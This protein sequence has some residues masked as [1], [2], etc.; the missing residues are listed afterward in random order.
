MAEETKSVK[1][2]VEHFEFAPLD[3]K[4][5]GKEKP[6]RILGLR[7]VTMNVTVNQENFYADNS[8]FAILDGGI[9][10][11]GLDLE[12]A[13]ISS[14]NK[15]ALLGVELENGME[16]YKKNIQLPYVACTFK[17]STNTG[18]AVWFGFVKGKFSLPSTDLST[19]EGSPNPN[20]DT[21]S[22]K[23]WSRGSDELMYVIAREDSADFDLE[24]F[25]NK[26]YGSA[27]PG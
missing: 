24:Q 16:L 15:Q 21:L 13:D 19:N 20:P 4:E 14:E 5:Q 12:V 23:L 2:G 9:S 8:I 10:E 25:K 3:E 6:R 18:K 27:F 22:G 7:K 1:V 17:T 11:L 26:V